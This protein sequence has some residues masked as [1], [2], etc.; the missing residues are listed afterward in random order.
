MRG[1]Q[2]RYRGITP[3]VVLLCKEIIDK[4]LRL[5]RSHSCRDT[6]HFIAIYNFKAV[7]HDQT[8]Q[9]QRKHVV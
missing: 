1:Q 9:T 5:F 7:D 2:H 3:V 6:D 4:A 8:L